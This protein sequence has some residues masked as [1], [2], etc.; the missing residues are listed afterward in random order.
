MAQRRCACHLV[1]QRANGDNT[2]CVSMLQD[3]ATSACTSACSCKCKRS[4]TEPLRC[5]DPGLGFGEIASRAGCW[6]QMASQR[7]L[8]PP[9]TVQAVTAR[10]IWVASRTTSEAR[11]RGS[12]QSGKM[13]H[14]STQPSHHT[15]PTCARAPSSHITV[16]RRVPCS[17]RAHAMGL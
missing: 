2:H 4:H 12:P 6:L 1:T 14:P 3:K 11:V 7:H 10:C 5:V 16:I 17:H 15:T 8:S 13:E 9:V